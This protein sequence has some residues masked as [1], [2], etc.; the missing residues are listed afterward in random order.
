MKQIIPPRVGGAILE[1]NTPLR[2]IFLVGELLPAAFEALKSTE[3][4]HTFGLY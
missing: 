1:E 2:E 4:S 3:S